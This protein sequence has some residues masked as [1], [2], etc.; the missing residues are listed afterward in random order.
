MWITSRV[1]C[2]ALVKEFKL[3]CA[4]YLLLVG[5]L[6]TGISAQVSPPASDVPSDQQVLAFLTA[7]IDW[8]RHCTAEEVCHHPATFNPVSA[9]I[10]DL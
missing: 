2:K 1:R 9:T 5:V 3:R 6:T 10:N 4:C 8:Y 7:S